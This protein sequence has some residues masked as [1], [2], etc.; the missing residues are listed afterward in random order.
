M[1]N[2]QKLFYTRHF[3]LE[4]KNG[5]VRPALNSP[6]DPLRSLVSGTTPKSKHF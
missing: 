4:K 5:P 6:P 3:K 2:L 1:T